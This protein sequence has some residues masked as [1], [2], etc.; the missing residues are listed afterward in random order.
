M[1]EK[2]KK[3]IKKVPI[4]RV[5]ACIWPNRTESGT[6]W[7]NV[8]AIRPYKDK[9][10]NWQ[11]SESFSYSDLPCVGRAMEDAMSWIRDRRESD[12]RNAVPAHAMDEGTST[13]VSNTGRKKGRSK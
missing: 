6:T 7:Y 2:K 4:G 9:Q 5:I 10:G 3:P 13:K 11:D 12:E 1:E 8:T